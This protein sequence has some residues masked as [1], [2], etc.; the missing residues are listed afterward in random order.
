M[1]RL[2][3]ILSAIP[4][5]DVT[6]GKP[7]LDDEVVGKR[8]DNANDQQGSHPVFGIGKIPV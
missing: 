6:P 5:R 7:A 1:N 8:E 4:L 2:S 3:E